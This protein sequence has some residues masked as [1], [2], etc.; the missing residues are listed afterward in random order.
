MRIEEPQF[1][2]GVAAAASRVDLWHR[3]LKEAGAKT[4]AEVGVW[5][6]EF[7]REMLARC[8]FI[9]CYYMIDPW[10]HLPDWN[11]PWNVAREEFDAVYEE[12]MSVTAFASSRRVVL[13]GRTTEVIGCI[14]DQSLDFAY[15]DGDHTLRGI[16]LDLISLFPKVKDNGFIGGDD[17]INDRPHHDASFEP[18]LVCPFSVYFA[19]AMRV[20]ML[21]LP[22]D[23]F[24][25]QKRPGGT[26]AFIDPTG[27]YGDLSLNRKL[28]S[29]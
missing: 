4:M 9:D 3:V 23:Q 12:A 1:Q 15:I 24:L 25:I 21:A 10:T 27:K 5:K 6:G 18:T 20:P 7:A 28:T 8:D 26:F 19:E 22:F 13:R 16:T 29:P 2:S 14:P 17:F 11:K